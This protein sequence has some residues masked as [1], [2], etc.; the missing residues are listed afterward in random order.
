[1]TELRLILIVVGVLFV[2]G[3]Y[4]WGKRN[5]KAEAGQEYVR[6]EED[7]LEKLNQQRHSDEDIP[8][9][10]PVVDLDDLKAETRNEPPIGDLDLDP[11]PPPEIRDRNRRGEQMQEPALFEQDEDRTGGELDEDANLVE[12]STAEPVSS[13]IEL[14]SKDDFLLDEPT[15]SK[16]EPTPRPPVDEQLI[17]VLHVMGH[18]DRQFDGSDLLEAMTEAGLR[19]GEMNI[20][21][22]HKN[23]DGSGPVLFSVANIVEPGTFD[24]QQMGDFTTPGVAMFM[25]LP[26]PEDGEKAFDKMLA[27]GRLMAQHLDGELKDESRSTLTQQAIGH[28]RERISEFQLKQLAKKK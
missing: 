23:P 25:Q 13:E 10:T 2:L 22:M 17:L 27:S 6:G 4:Y 9:V 12:S 1:M 7:W 28:M 18:P 3:I 11:E 8:T 14:E 15:Q 16:A 21:H 26:G 24:L 19:Y 5:R 20:F